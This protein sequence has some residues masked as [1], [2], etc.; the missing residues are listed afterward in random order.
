MH[1]VAIV[2]IIDQTQIA[3]PLLESFFIN[4]NSWKWL[5]L[6]AKLTS[7][8]CTFQYAPSRIP[9]ETE[10]LHR[11]LDILSLLQQIDC[12]SFEEDGESTASFLLGERHCFHTMLWTIY[13]W[14]LRRKNG[15][16]LTGIQMSPAA[17]LSM[18]I[19]WKEL[20]AFGPTELGTT[21]RGFYQ[22]H[23]KPGWTKPF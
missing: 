15:L 10:V 5:S 6:L 7:L 1:L 18:V 19:T 14:N 13:S 11:P 17:F 8:N 16:E 23:S 4:A 9:L 12:K 3:M 22:I 2:E 20:I 21:R